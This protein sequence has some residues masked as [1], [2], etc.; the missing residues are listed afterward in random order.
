MLV[1]LHNFFHALIFSA[2]VE[3]VVVLALCTVLKKRKEIALL[4]IVGTAGTIPYVWY[5]FPTMLWYSP[6]GS[7]ICG[8]SFA[9]I[10]EAILYR[11]AG[12]LSWRESF[13]FSAS[14]NAASF[15]MGK[16]L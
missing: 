15:F 13:L 16:V 9:F 6:L 2:L 10:A 8:E 3:A 4:A 14:A 11:M 1:Y 7:V 12:K 5:V